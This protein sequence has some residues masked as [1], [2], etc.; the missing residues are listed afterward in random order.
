MP[1]A[2]AGQPLSDPPTFAEEAAGESSEQ[3]T[4]TRR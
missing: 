3:S 2:V 1:E 4:A